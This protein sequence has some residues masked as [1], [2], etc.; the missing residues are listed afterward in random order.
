MDCSKKKKKSWIQVNRLSRWWFMAVVNFFLGGEGGGRWVWLLVKLEKIV[1][2]SLPS[3]RF[4]IF[5][6]F[7]FWIFLLNQ[8]YV[9]NWASHSSYGRHHCGKYKSQACY[10][11]IPSG[12]HHWL[13]F[14]SAMAQYSRQLASRDWGVLAI[15]TCDRSYRYVL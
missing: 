4:E 8:H 1:G 11:A 14:E 5:L 3:V 2:F 15:I 7:L 6:L 9:D 10:L 12:N 13:H